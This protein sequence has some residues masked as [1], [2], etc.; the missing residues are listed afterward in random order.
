MHNELKLDA[1]ELQGFAIADNLCAES[2][3]LNL[4]FDSEMYLL[5]KYRFI[6]R[7]YLLK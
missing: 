5:S 3:K 6:C 4:Y 2:F 7:K 1:N